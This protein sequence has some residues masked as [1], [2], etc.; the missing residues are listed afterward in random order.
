MTR[1]EV[2]FFAWSD[3]RIPYVDGELIGDATGLPIGYASQM[4]QWMTQAAIN[5]KINNNLKAVITEKEV[6]VSLTQMAA[7]IGR[8]PESIEE[9]RRVVESYE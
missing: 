8:K 2:V 6:P 4:L 7:L 3:L 9:A 1:I 5:D